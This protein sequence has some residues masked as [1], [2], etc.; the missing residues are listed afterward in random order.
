MSDLPHTSSSPRSMRRLIAFAFKSLALIAF[1]VG[2]WCAVWLLVGT[3]PDRDPLVFYVAVPIAGFA[4]VA[5]M[6]IW[7]ARRWRRPVKK[8]EAL[9]PATRAATEPIAALLEIRGGPRALAELLRDVLHNNRQQ[10]QAVSLLNE[11][12]RQRV[13]V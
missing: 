11:E 13:A 1:T 4:T 12:I 5:A 2:N 8:I 6:T 10:R 7:H 9:I 3:R